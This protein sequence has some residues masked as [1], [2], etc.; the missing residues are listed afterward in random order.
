MDTYICNRFFTDVHSVSGYPFLLLA[1][2]S[3]NDYSY[4]TSFKAKLKLDSHSTVDLGDLRLMK[5]EQT[6][7][8]E[9]RAFQSLASGSLIP[10]ESMSSICSLSSSNHYYDELAKLNIDIAREVL[11]TLRDASFLPDVKK[12]FQD[13]PCFQISL[14]RDSISRKLLDE[15]GARFG[16]T[17]AL[18]NE[19]E[20]SLLLNGASSPHKFH[21]DFDSDGGAP[22]RMQAIVGLNGVGK[23]QVMA[24]LAMLMSRFSLESIKE[25]RSILQGND[26]LSPVPS[27][28]GVVAVSF[29]AFDE[30]ERPN[31]LQS[32][33]FQ[34]SYCGLQNDA[35]GLKSKDELL[36]EIQSAL[37]TL[38]DDKRELLKNTLGNLVPVKDIDSFIDRPTESDALYQTLSAGQR[39]ALNCIFHILSRISR[40]TLILFDEP[41]LHL[42][43]Q[44]LTGLL[45]T[46][47]DILDKLDSFA[48][49]A[50]HSPLVVQQL[51]M[52][53]VH[54]LR[55][56]RMTP[57]V[58]KPTF[59]TFGESLSELTKFVFSSAEADRDYKSVLD[60][61]FAECGGDTSAVRKLFGNQLSIG[62]DIYLESLNAKRQFS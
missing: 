20:V 5:Y 36:K 38:T 25:D 30:F 56:D 59:Q 57:M 39:L 52:E 17:Q 6:E 60:R 44:L 43:P 11:R 21:F 26:S 19:F 46:L 54:V 12:I 51:P 3:W 18:I 61:M 35:G 32:E 45:S 49:V 40:R 28:Y 31:H 15:A 10:K 58:L 13:Q 47:S 23:T 29:S 8:I 48:I 4:Y 2:D 7:G 9:D 33:E 41:E 42:H 50:T 62:A 22:R 53:C 55:R 16:S 1:R 14:L 27:I 24:R 37:A 34:Y